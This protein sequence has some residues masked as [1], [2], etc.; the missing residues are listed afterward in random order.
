[1]KDWKVVWLLDTDPVV[2]TEPPSPLEP[3]TSHKHT[4]NQSKDHSLILKSH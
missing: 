2:F 4:E 1:M 3:L